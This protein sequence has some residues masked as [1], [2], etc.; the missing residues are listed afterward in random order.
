[1]PPGFL[2]SRLFT[3]FGYLLS[4]FVTYI[5]HTINCHFH[6]RNDT[7]MVCQVEP[8]PE[9]VPVEKEQSVTLKWDDPDAEDLDTGFSFTYKPDPDVNNINP[10][11]TIP[12][13]NIINFYHASFVEEIKANAVSFNKASAPALKIDSVVLFN[14]VDTLIDANRWFEKLYIFYYLWK[15]VRLVRFQRG[16]SDH[17]YWKKC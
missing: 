15:C 6:N 5:L 8:K 10:N 2:V 11:V 17:G 3:T 9:D 1:M 14:S 13:Y 7:R 12:R 16:N 4:S